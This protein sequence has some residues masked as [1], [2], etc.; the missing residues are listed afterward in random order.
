MT[1]RFAHSRDRSPVW[2]FF[3][4][5]LLPISAVV[6]AAGDDFCA[7]YARRAVSQWGVM[8]THPACHVADSPRW[9]GDYWQHLAGCSK[10]PEQNLRQELDARDQHLQACGALPPGES[11][12]R[13]WRDHKDSSWTSASAWVTL[14]GIWYPLPSGHTELRILGYG[15]NFSQHDCGNQH[16]EELEADELPNGYVTRVVIETHVDASLPACAHVDKIIEFQMA[17]EGKCA[18]KLSFFPSR[19]AWHAGKPTR[20]GNFRFTCE[21][22]PSC[23]E[24]LGYPGCHEPRHRSWGRTS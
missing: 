21:Q 5:A 4:L 22:P 10:Q 16:F 17:P 6:N 13:T 19:D 1:S 18:A 24:I 3:L 11:F 12:A 7:P 20:S 8:L 9:N 15:Y 2:V 14:L 23:N